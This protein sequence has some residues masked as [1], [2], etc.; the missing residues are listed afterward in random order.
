MLTAIVAFLAGLLIG[1]FLNV[2]IYRMPRDLSVIRPSRS[3]CP[4]CE[5]TIAW[6]DNIPVLSY[7]LL[8]GKCRHCGKPIPWRYPVV[9]LATACLFAFTA[10]THGAT[11]PVTY[12]LCIFSALLVGLIF[13]D[14][15]ERILPDEF[16]VGG[17]I[18][19]LGFA[20]L[21]PRRMGVIGMLLPMDWNPRVA[22]VVESAIS[23][24]IAA[25]LFLALRQAYAAVRK[26]E[27]LGLGDVK[28]AGMLGAFMGFEMT[29]LTVM[30]ASV[31]GLVISLIYIG[32]TRKDASSFE[33]P[34]GSYIG[35]TA[36]AAAVGLLRHPL[37]G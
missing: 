5:K 12:R 18:L 26:R 10:A 17:V 11:S 15:E 24:A 9:E 20:A 21:A 27:G 30:A 23:A 16:T 6:Y 35:L 13:S 29:L 36:L 37:L 31:L 33:F 34:F 25:G 28:M 4:E 2:C 19:G 22:S 14:L 32:V 1:S 3:F 7:L 8:R